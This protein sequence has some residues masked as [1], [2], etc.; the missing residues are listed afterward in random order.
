MTF[1]LSSQTI[2]LTYPQCTLTSEQLFTHLK[3]IHEQYRIIHI[4]VAT[5]KH[6]DGNTHFHAALKL[7]KPVDTTNARFWDFNEFHP[8]LL[9]PRNYA[10]WVDYC[11][12]EKE[13]L[14]EGDY[15]PKSSRVTV[16]EETVIS[17]ATSLTK[18]EFL[19]WAGVNRVTYA[20][21]IWELAN[22]DKGITI[23]NETAING[24][25]Q[26]RLQNFKFSVE[27]LNCRALILIGESGAGKTTWAKTNIP[28]PCLFVTHIDELKLFRKGYHVS[29]LFDDV[30]FK[31]YPIQA[32]IHLVDFFDSRTIHVRY[33]TATIP[34]RTVKFFTCNEDPVD[35]SHPAIQRRCKIVRLNETDLK[36]IRQSD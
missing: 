18:L 5:E 23:T 30:S 16:S 14:E 6:K 31:H 2:G 7:G 32:Q 17:N 29:I 9:R 26:S 28:K 15:R 35:L 22:S 33:G 27:W 8:N 21:K 34:E 36:C 1:R 13:F 20:E 4:L 19:I 3:T 25:M 10:N 11:K 12:K 24:I